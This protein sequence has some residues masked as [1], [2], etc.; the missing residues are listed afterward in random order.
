MIVISFAPAC[1][2]VSHIRRLKY[3]EVFLQGLHLAERKMHLKLGGLQFGHRM[4][5]AGIHGGKLH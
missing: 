4:V 2:S 5:P 1:S 3:M